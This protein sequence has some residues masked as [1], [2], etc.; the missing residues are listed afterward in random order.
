MKICG[1]CNTE[2]DDKATRC[3]VCGSTLLR[4]N[5]GPTTADEEYA[6]L[7]EEV[8]DRRKLRGIILGIGIA[9]III[10]VIVII[11]AVV[12]YFKSPERAMAKESERLLAS[13]QSDYD[14]GLYRGAMITLETINPQWKDYEKAEKLYR[15]AFKQEMYGCLQE[16][17]NTHDY[18]G[19]IF[20]INQN[21]SDIW[22]DP[23]ISGIYEEAVSN[24]ITAIM[25]ET[26]ALIAGED[27]ESAENLLSTALTVVGNEQNLAEK[28]YE[29][30]QKIIETE[31]AQ[32]TLKIAEFKSRKDYAGLYQYLSELAYMN[33]NYTEMLNQCET[34]LVDMTLETAAEY[35]DIRD[36]EKAIEILENAKEIY[37]S[38]EFQKK[39]EDYSQHTP[40]NLIECTVIEEDH[41]NTGSVE[42]C[43][44][45]QHDSVLKFNSYYNYW[46]GGYA[47]FFLDSK[48]SRLT[49]EFMGEKEISKEVKIA[50]RIYGDGELLFESDWLTRTSYPENI[51]LNITGIKQLKIEYLTKDSS[52]APGFGIFDL[53][54]S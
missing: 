45:N 7:C 51:D 43:F 26:D 32:I 10:T 41:M 4:Q 16:Y 34:E 44:G 39:I 1:Y 2:Y 30:E 46:D 29:I 14:A 13:A 37:Y 47:V 33:E 21:I 25:V 42:D 27:F 49:G 20:Y 23:E 24:Y 48:F 8:H 35:A 38:E 3:P 15:E 40:R 22:A 17:Q 5:Q 50:C 19:I 9:G 12:G 53:M 28:L 54:V 31:N 52:D 36:F 18:E 6:R 11:S